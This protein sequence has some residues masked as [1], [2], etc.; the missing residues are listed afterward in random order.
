VFGDEAR[1]NFLLGD[2]EVCSGDG[3]VDPLGSGVI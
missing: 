2:R 1:L 3:A